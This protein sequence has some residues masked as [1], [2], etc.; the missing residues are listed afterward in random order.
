MYIM[1]VLFLYV[2]MFKKQFYI[3]GLL[4]FLW[5]TS[6]LAHAYQPTQKKQKQKK[7]KQKQNQKRMNNKNKSEIKLNKK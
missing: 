7:N 6:Y 1:S 3:E 4:R 2:H 5:Q